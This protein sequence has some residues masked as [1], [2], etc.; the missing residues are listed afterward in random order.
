MDATFLTLLNKAGSFSEEE[1][2]LLKN[3]LKF[4][5]FKKNDFLLK[6]GDICSSLCFVVSGSFCQYQ[7]DDDSN[8][9]IIEIRNGMFLYT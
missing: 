1:A 4:R 6:E 3:E 5:E 9:I 8:R 2:L 7:T